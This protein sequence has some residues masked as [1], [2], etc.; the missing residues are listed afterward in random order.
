MSTPVW[1]GPESYADDTYPPPLLKHLL[2]PMMAQCAA[3]GAC[4]ALFDEQ[5]GQMRI[6]L[7]VRARQV[8]LPG[9]QSGLNGSKSPVR[10]GTVHLESDTP[11]SLSVVPARPRP[12][13]QPL[14]SL[15]AGGSE[16]DEIPYQQSQL[17]APGTLYAKGRDLIGQAWS[18]N[19]AFIIS[20]E[21]YISQFIDGPTPSFST[22][23]TPTWYL[24]VPIRES[25]LVE[26]M[27]AGR[28]SPHPQRHQKILGV[29]VL[30][31]T[32]TS[33]GPGFHTKQRSEA[34]HAV[35]R[36]A[37]YLQ[38]DR[39]QR[40]QRRHQEY[41]RGLQEIS[42]IFPTSL[43]LS[44][45]VDRVYQFTSQVVDV[46]SLL[47]TLFDRDTEKI[48]DVFAICKGKRVEGLPE[49]FIISP[50]E[51]RPIWWQVTQEEKRR[52]QF[53]PTQ[54]EEQANRYSE[55]L[56]GIWGDQSSSKSFL[57]LPMKMFTRVTGS[58]CITSTHPNAYREEEIQ[59][60][61]TMVQ[62]ITVSIENV[63]LYERDKKSLREAKEREIQLAAMN[64]A[65]QSI[66]SI[67]DLK[68]LLNNLVTAVAMLV[69]AEVCAFFALSPEKDELIAQA[70]YGTPSKN[71]YAVQDGGDPFK[72]VHSKKEHDALIASIRLPFKD[73]LLEPSTREGFF[74]LNH[75]MM[76]ELIQKSGEGGAVFL[77]MTAAQQ[78]L[79]IPVSYHTKLVGV[80][81]VHT[82]KGSRFFL[83]K[84][85]GMLLALC[86]QA[87]TAIRNAQLF[88]QRELAYAELEHMNKLKDEFLVTASHELRTPLSAIS[89]Y[90]S[91]LKRQSTR[92]TPQ[93]ILRY[94]T[95]ISGAAQQLTDLLSNITE[96]AKMGTID[97]KLDLQ[98]GPVQ[99]LSAAEVAV[100]LLSVNVEQQVE[101]SVDR[102]LWVRG[103]P[104]RVRQ[105]MSNLLENAAKYS[106]PQSRIQLTARATTLAQIQGLLSPDQLDRALMPED[107]EMPMIL[108]QVRDEGEGILPDDQLRIFEK[109]VRA[110][111]SLTTPVRGSGLGLFI[112]RRY[113]EAMNGKLW[114][115]RS[116]AN[117]GSVFSFYLPAIEAPINTEEQEE[118]NERE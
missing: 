8:Q 69:N 24:V 30:Y 108:V 32:V 21:A 68:E 54:D 23:I 83:P 25:T 13:S 81:A 87:A 67:L 6:R 64:S 97:K 95:K 82:P 36:I 85:V 38:N 39:L 5:L 27:R 99:I 20:H 88:E 72:E 96:A 61:E 34:L 47:L 29:I 48:Y 110:P 92:I 59:I 115:E 106:P 10:R 1:G 114:L 35:E 118:Q 53:S 86:A 4:I 62:I 57:L 116:V 98:I 45:L 2:K 90:A 11:S 46:S 17:F 102:N 37:L 77:Q 42:T 14:P 111:R 100:N 78:M 50:K 91:L 9:E 7:H 60:L 75:S 107:A 40:T 55:L 58:L 73:T 44:A 63:K 66:S 105:V 15:Q 18:K 43:K 41:L 84:E 104:L 65:L 3:Q 51:E 93:Q 49:Q 56:T 76:E 31:Q 12:I 28:Y 33:T 74:Y 79:V 117:E 26:D 16:L 89:G 22:D 94:G 103:D 109:F 70:V 113:V 19:D 52:L 71:T 80:L 101:L 112:C